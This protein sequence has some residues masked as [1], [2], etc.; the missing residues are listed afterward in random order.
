[1]KKNLFLAMIVGLTGTAFGADEAQQQEPNAAP[2]QVEQ[3]EEK[4][5]ASQVWADAKPHVQELGSQATELYKED[6]KPTVMD[7]KK[8]VVDSGRKIWGGIKGKK[9]W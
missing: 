3:Q 7:A 5:L 1:M 2:Q 6:I 8:E 4:P 9:F